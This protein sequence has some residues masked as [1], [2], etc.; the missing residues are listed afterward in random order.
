[1][2]HLVFFLEGPSEKAMLKGLLP[3]LLS[4]DTIPQYVVFEGKKDLERQLPPAAGSRRCVF[5]S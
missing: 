1:M 3:R 4:G 2:I 5:S